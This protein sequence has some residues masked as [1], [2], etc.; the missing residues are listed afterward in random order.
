[1]SAESRERN[2]ETLR[3]IGIGV[4]LFIGAL[5]VVALNVAFYRWVCACV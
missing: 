3:Q 1:M 2:R 5:A 4:G